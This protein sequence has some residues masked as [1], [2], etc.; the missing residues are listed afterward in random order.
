MAAIVFNLTTFALFALIFVNARDLVGPSTIRQRRIPWFAIGLTG[1][2]V[3]GVLVQLSWAGAMDA[4]DSDPARTGWWR[5]FTSMFMQNGGLIGTAYNLLTLAVIVALAEWFWRGPL[6]L[7]LFVAGDILPHY[8]DLLIGI[9]ASPS[10]DPRNFAGSSGVTYFLGAT[11]VGAAL[12]AGLGRRAVLVA[13][14]VPAMGLALWF[15]QENGHGLVAVYGVVIGA[16]VFLATKRVL[17]PGRDLRTPPAHPVGAV[18]D[19]LRRDQAA[20]RR[21]AQ[22][23]PR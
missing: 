20:D 22:L 17:D 7:V 3:L 12:L 10:T 8:L 6:M 1:L 4:F 2:A 21:G 23:P 15:A 9:G 11:L 5:V 14:T 18:L 13:V 19:L 16:V